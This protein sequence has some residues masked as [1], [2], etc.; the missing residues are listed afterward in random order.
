MGGRLADAVGVGLL[1][2]A[3]PAT[4]LPR[5][6]RLSRWLEKDFFHFP[7]IWSA[8]FI[9]S[10]AQRGRRREL[11]LAV[12]PLPSCNNR[13]HITERGSTSKKTLL[14]KILLCIS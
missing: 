12:K 1:T 3:A 5:D 10:Q 6:T 11:A 9:G 7:L 4:S 2:L 14:T 8:G 13:A